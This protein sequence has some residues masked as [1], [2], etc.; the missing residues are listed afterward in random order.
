MSLVTTDI[1]DCYDYIFGLSRSECD[2]YDPKGDHELDFNTS[3]SG[4]YLD[5]LQP[6]SVLA[7]LEKCEQDV[8]EAMAMARE[9]AVK[10]FVMDASRELLKHNQLRAQPYSGVIGRRTNTRDRSI[11]TTY[12]GVHIICKKIVGGTLTIKKI[13]TLFNFTGTV[14]VTVADN[15]GNTWG[16]YVLNTTL[17]TWT[18][19]DITDLELPL[20]SQ[21]VD[22]VEYFLYYNVGA[23]Q[24]RNN[25]L[26]CNCGKGLSFNPNRPYYLWGHVD[27]YRWA[28]S[29]MVG[30]FHTDDIT[31]FTNIDKNYGGY[32]ALNGLN[33]EID[34]DC[35][36][37]MTF[38]RD[39]LN[40]E[41]DPLAIAIAFAVRYKAAEYLADWIFSSREMSFEKLI[42]RENLATEQ[43][44]WIAKY[45][46]LIEY[47]AQNVDI[48]KTDCLK[49]KDQYRIEK[50]TLLL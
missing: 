31:E 41:S 45:K 7:S 2:C 15:L 18:E 11:S 14:T 29:V 25:D 35:D 24:P 43:A 46:E 40:F 6:L 16:P 47:I 21:Y 42:N 39:E 13:H 22:N 5:E 12:A 28:E 26:C 30:G 17:D 19:N 10:I 37:G 23:N 1:Y 50:G 8:W 49:C 27:A 38:C 44:A 20:W 34:I 9:N 33:L 36:Y 3:Y 48:E 4:L 32:S